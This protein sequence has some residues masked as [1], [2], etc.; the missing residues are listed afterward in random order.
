MDVPTLFDSSV[1][2]GQGGVQ[3]GSG[4]GQSGQ[5][6]TLALA[7][8]PLFALSGG[9]GGLTAASVL[10]GS[11]QAGVPAAVPA[12]GGAGGGGGGGFNNAGGGGGGAGEPGATG[13]YD[14]VALGAGGGGGGQ[15]AGTTSAQPFYW[16]T[17]SCT[18]STSTSG[19]DGQVTLA[20]YTGT[21]CAGTPVLAV[22]NTTEQVAP[23]P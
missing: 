10:S 20:F 4:N 14:S 22:Y 11:G 12:V 1:A 19:S 18:F 5:G 9:A 17:G 16:Q 13:T 6:L 23:L 8:I 2:G 21:Y 7:G 3:N 15:G